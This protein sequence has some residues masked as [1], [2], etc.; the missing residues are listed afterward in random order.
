MRSGSRRRAIA[1]VAGLLGLSLL[2][3]TVLF[4]WFTQD[5]TAAAGVAGL[6]V[7]A[8]AVSSSAVA[9]VKWSASASPSLA[10]GAA[11]IQRAMDVLAGMVAQQWKVEAAI[12]SLDDPDPMPVQWRLTEQ[13]EV[14]DHPD[15]MASGSWPLAGSS[16][17]ITELTEQFR[18]LRRRRLVIVGGPGTGKTTLAV[19]LLRELLATRQDDE[20]IPVLLS[21][22]GWD[23][24]AFPLLQD[25]LA[26]Q[27]GQDYPALRAP[28]LGT[29]LPQA[30]AAR[31]QVF[32]VLD[33]LDEL[34]VMARAAVITALNRSLGGDDQ[35]ILTSRTAEFTQAVR[36][37]KDVLTSAA[38]IEPAPLTHAA[39]ADYL[40][41][42]LPPEPGPVWEQILTEL[43]TRRKQAGPA[44][45]LAETVSTPLGLWLLRQ[46][47]LLSGA[48]PE[49][50]VQ[51]GRFPTAAS[52]RAHLFDL[53][54]PALVATRQPSANPG[55]LFRPRRGHDPEMVRDWL[56][57]LA[58][59]LNRIPAG[60]GRTGTRDFAWWRLARH[61]LRPRTLPLVAILLAV[62]IIGFGAG[63][64]AA[65]RAGPAGG[66]DA[67]LT[68]ALAAA[69]GAG[70]MFA[71]AVGPRDGMNTSLWAREGPGFADLRATGRIPL[72][73]R[74]VLKYMPTPGLTAGLVSGLAAGLVSGPRTGLATGLWAALG[75]AALFGTVSGLIAWAETPTPAGRANTPMSN[76]R[77]DRRMNLI[78]VISG[79]VV[80]AFVFGLVGGLSGGLVGALTA[81]LVFGLVIR[82]AS[83]LTSPGQHHAGMAYTAA[84]FGLARSHRLPRRLMP[85]L[86]DMH[87]LGLLRAVGPIYQFRHAELQDHL[88]A[89]YRAREQAGEQRNAANGGSWRA[90]RTADP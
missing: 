18:A 14:M 67:R 59:H 61:T 39:A 81:G 35:L 63:I 64:G 89:T 9:L 90:R 80:S 40:R 36:A 17:Q 47:Y 53:L 13:R 37:A 50:L 77:A 78:R 75:A 3:G 74:L 15:N 44:D 41:S 46:T 83:K 43:Q 52:L 33:G 38:V 86:D 2:F 71:L 88:A 25:W 21:V 31:G 26:E 85:F 6:V 60:D 1:A 19:Q 42:C 34:P 24:R 66:L 87:R 54:I 79:G 27:L 48:D 10:P 76:W 57:Y 72:L 5:L 23:T 32:P 8:M 58:D 20:P 11:D 70:S 62:P 82:I 49:S 51:A 45:A 29:D 69:L 56:G 4:A 12:R 73:V 84:T 7:L 68:I 28:E 55:D 16:A 65:F 22:A 30:L